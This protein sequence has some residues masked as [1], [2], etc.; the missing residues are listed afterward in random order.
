[1]NMYQAEDMSWTIQRL[2]DRVSFSGWFF[3]VISG[4]CLW[5]LMFRLFI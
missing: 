4:L 1:M 3:A 2:N 5:A